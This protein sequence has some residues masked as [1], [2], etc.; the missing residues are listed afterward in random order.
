MNISNLNVNSYSD[1]DLYKIFKLPSNYT[2]NQLED[3]VGNL[4]QIVSNSLGIQNK[5]ETLIFINDCKA[6][7]YTKLKNNN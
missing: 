6:R 7:L 4:T 1:T 2:I 5:H 3:S